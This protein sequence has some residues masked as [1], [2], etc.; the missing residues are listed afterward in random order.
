MHNEYTRLLENGLFFAR[1][2]ETIKALSNYSQ[3]I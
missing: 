2:F 3:R 1:V